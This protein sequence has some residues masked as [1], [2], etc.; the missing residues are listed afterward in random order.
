MKPK[1]QVQKSPIF[2][3]YFMKYFEI[4]TFKPLKK[5]ISSMAQYEMAQKHEKTDLG[6][7]FAF[8]VG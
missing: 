5:L 1:H 3:F 2:Y 7:K 4:L 8:F 6:P